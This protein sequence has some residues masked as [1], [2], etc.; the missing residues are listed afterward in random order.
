MEN[1][2]GFIICRYVTSDIT[3]IYWNECIKQIRLFYPQEPI[4]VLDGGSD[5]N[6]T[7]NDHDINLNNCNII[8]SEFKGTGELSAYQY[9]YNN[10]FCTKAIIIHDS[11]FIKQKI[12]I[13]HSDI[14]YLWNF[15]PVWD[16][17]PAR[18]D[19]INFLS[20]LKHYD[21]LINTLNSNQWMG[22]FGVMSAITHTFLTKLQHKYQLF[23]LLQHIKTKQDRMNM[24]RIFSIICYNETTNISC[25]YGDII[26][27]YR[28]EDGGYKLP[29]YHYKN[30]TTKQLE[31]YPIIKVWT[32]R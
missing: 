31:H 3:N 11:V 6:F 15:N 2:I 25:I 30:F 17:D 16:A 7:I 10:P 20:H 13:D 4:I 32:Y 22:C 19:S 21:S 1:T 26:Y 27:Y 8:E 23:I 24:E 9:Y 14:Q 28:I 18:T 29:Y 12:P 5:K